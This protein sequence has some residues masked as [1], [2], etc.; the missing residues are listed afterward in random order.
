MIAMAVSYGVSSLPVMV[1]SDVNDWPV[2]GVDYV[3]KQDAFHEQRMAQHKAEDA[4]QAQ[5]RA[6]QYREA[7]QS[8][9]RQIDRQRLITNAS[10]T[11][12]TASAK[13]FLSPSAA[14]E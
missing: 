13:Q 1:K 5:Q 10:K 7:Q 11:T 8:V 14:V 6:E 4:A 2:C 9:Q 12:K 3:R